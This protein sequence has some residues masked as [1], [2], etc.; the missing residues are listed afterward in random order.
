MPRLKALPIAVGLLALSASAVL[1]FNPLPD[2]SADGLERATGASN[3]TLPARPGD[4]PS[5][6]Q[7]VDSV[8]AAVGHLVDAAAHGAAVA[9]VAQAED[10]TPETNHGA[11][12]SAAAKDNHGQATAA[13][14][15]PAGA[16]RPEGA[17]KPDD[18]GAPDDTGAP[19]GVG[20]P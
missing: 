11:D 6:A 7:A 17:G 9:A 16:G 10:T 8:A 14:H 18:P 2:A 13:E 19:E 15:V 20:R 3:R 1:A 4:L 5:V 12:V